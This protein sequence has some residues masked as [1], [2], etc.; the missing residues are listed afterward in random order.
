M[1]LSSRS[2]F[3]FS[4]MPLAYKIVDCEKRRQ[5]RHPDAGL[6]VLCIAARSPVTLDHSIH[7]I[8][9]T[10][11]RDPCCC[12][13]SDAPHSAGE[14]HAPAGNPPAIHHSRDLPDMPDPSPGPVWPMWG[15]IWSESP[16]RGAFVRAARRRSATTTNP[17][18]RCTPVKGLLRTL[19][20][21]ASCFTGSRMID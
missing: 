11:I 10:G 12:R 9:R 14:G 3:E 19:K 1:L 13:F 20:N 2:F 4:C 15:S 6:R 8:A 21:I 18:Y 7:G 5:S 16:N 17:I